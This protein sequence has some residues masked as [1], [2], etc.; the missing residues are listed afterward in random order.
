MSCSSH[1]RDYLYSGD[2]TFVSKFSPL[3]KQL[4]V[5][6]VVCFINL[7]KFPCKDKLFA[8][9]LIGPTIPLLSARMQ[10]WYYLVKELNAL[11]LKNFS[12]CD[13]VLQF[14]NAENHISS[15]SRNHDFKLSVSFRNSIAD[16]ECSK[17]AKAHLEQFT[18]PEYCFLQFYRFYRAVCLVRNFVF[19][20][21]GRFWFLERIISQLLDDANHAGDWDDDDLLSVTRK[22]KWTNSHN[23]ASKDCCLESKLGLYDDWVSNVESSVSN[24]LSAV[25]N[26]T[27][28]ALIGLVADKL[29]LIYS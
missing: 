26:F 18:Y 15:V 10:N 1:L 22:S 23:Y 27:S 11:F 13:V 7:W 19:S 5:L 9:R 29:H 16:Y 28:S 20:E 2:Q 17:L 6:F 8:F 3:L 25:W 21:N 4:L 14:D 12:R 24:Q